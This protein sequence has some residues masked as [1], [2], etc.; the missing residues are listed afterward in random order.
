[1]ESAQRALLRVLL[2]RILSLG[3]ISQRTYSKAE[4]LLSSATDLP[5]LFRP[6]LCPAEEADAHGRA[7]NPQ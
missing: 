6:P 7:Q 5:E 2:D 1:M 3:L 4:D